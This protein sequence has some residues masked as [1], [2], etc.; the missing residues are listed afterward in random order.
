MTSSEKEI[1]DALEEI[2]PFM[3]VLTPAEYKEKCLDHIVG[4]TGTA[5]GIR[6]I[7]KSKKL[8]DSF[9]DLICYD[10]NDKV[11]LLC[12][13]VIVNLSSSASSTEVNNHLLNPDVIYFL[14]NVVVHKDLDSSDLAAMLLSNMTQESSNCELVASKL[15][16]HDKVTVEKLVDAFCTPVYNTHCHLHHLGSF[17]SNLTLLKDMRLLFLKENRLIERV[18]TFTAYEESSVRRF[19]VAAIIKNCLFETDHHDWLLSDVD[20]LPHLLLPLAGPEEF[21]EEDNET[22]PIDL[23]YLPPD[24]KREPNKEI[25]NLLLESLFQLCATK[26]CRLKM[27]KNGTYLIMRELHKATAEDDPIMVNLE[28]LVY[29]LIGDEPDSENENLWDVEVPEHISSKLIQ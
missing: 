18:L 6:G 17:L 26:V 4:M 3:D 24:K 2:L 28:N 1:S 11:R 10:K 7:V 14:L 5:D 15:R 22:L 29:V 9:I 12:F 13:Q 25:K 16:E 8:L 19:S 20:I 21:D 27:K 23:Q